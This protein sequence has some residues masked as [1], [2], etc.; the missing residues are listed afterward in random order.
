MLAIAASGLLALQLPTAR[1][2]A[3]G[4]LFHTPAQR[5]TLEQDVPPPPVIEAPAPPPAPAAAGTALRIDGI[6]RRS[7]GANTVWLN[8]EMAP[9]PPGLHLAA[10]HQRVLIPEAEP[11]RRLRV[12]DTWPVADP[13]AAPSPRPRSTARNDAR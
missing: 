10:D 2:D 6:L 13:G 12:G 9:L 1:A 5:E 11:H 3:F 8:G 7:D 4:R